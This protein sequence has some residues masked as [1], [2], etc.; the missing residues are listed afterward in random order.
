MTKNSWHILALDNDDLPDLGERVI[1]CVGDAFVGEGYLKQ[2]KK[3][4]RYCDFAPLENYMSHGVTAW[5]PMP[6]PPGKR[7]SP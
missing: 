7:K 6:R 4:Y 5:M 2:D 1:I 3:W